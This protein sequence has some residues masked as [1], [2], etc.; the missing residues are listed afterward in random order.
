MK[1]FSLI[2]KQC[3]SYNLQGKVNGNWN[4]NG[5]GYKANTIF[6]YFVALS[7]VH[8][9]G[10][11]LIILLFWTGWRIIPKPK[12]TIDWKY[13]IGVNN[14]TDLA[15]ICVAFFVVM[16][17][18]FLFGSIKWISWKLIFE[19]SEIRG[20]NYI[21]WIVRELSVSILKPNQR[22]TNSSEKEF[23]ELSHHKNFQR[24]YV[25][26][27]FNVVFDTNLVNIWNTHG[28][29]KLEKKS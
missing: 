3:L 11:K 28:L 10:G 17:L 9:F 24:N 16:V 27:G 20:L 2:A 8:T 25:S 7:L 15:A 5:N 14:R 19:K 1:A 18:E 23:F 6:A 22:D 4:G 13:R 12:T 26:N 29:F 21:H